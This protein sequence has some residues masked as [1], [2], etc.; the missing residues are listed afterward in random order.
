MKQK[1]SKKSLFKCITFTFEGKEVCAIQVFSDGAIYINK[2]PR[3][4]IMESNIKS[5]QNDNGYHRIYLH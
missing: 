1:I 5:I 4:N 3:V 2:S